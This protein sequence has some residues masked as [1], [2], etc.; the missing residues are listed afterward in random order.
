[1]YVR[2]YPIYGMVFGLSY[3]NS[4]MD[5]QI[6]PEGEEQIKEH[7]IQLTLGIIGVNFTVWSKQD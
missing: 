1:M 7:A 3:W 6:M 4:D 5:D 2:M